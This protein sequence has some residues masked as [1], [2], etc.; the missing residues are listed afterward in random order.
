MPFTPFHFGIVLAGFLF[1]KLHIV[2]LAVS[3]V[4][5]DLEPAYYMFISPRPDGILH[6]FFHTYLGA[7]FLALVVGFF[8]L[9]TKNIW[10]PILKELHLLPESPI[11]VSNDSTA[12]IS[13]GWIFASSFLGAYSHIFFDSFMHADLLPFWPLSDAN[14]FLGQF[15]LELLHLLLVFGLVLSGV[16]WVRRLVRFES[17]K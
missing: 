1:R 7:T 11:R 9:K 12:S 17:E 3:A 13:F 10:N 4:I 2:A 15:D 6:G 5:M 8:F 14:P 16:L